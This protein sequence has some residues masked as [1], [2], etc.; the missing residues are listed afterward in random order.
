MAEPGN[1][2]GAGALAEALVTLVPLRRRHLRSV[3]RIEQQV[4]PRPWS[5]GVFMGELGQHGSRHYV[6]ARAQGRLVGYA[7]LMF[8]YDEAHVTNIAVD[9]A[10]QRHH[11]GTRLLVNLFHA[12]LRRPSR[13]ITLEVRVSNTGAQAMYRRFGFETEGLRRNYYAETGED[14]LVMWARDIAHP[15]RLAILGD[16]EQTVAATTVDETVTAAGI[17][18]GGEDEAQ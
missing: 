16:I 17:E 9:P 12:A 2:V 7:G 8:G 1:D 4:Y 11:V 14:A 3:L 13:D 15:A 18:S 6:G 5:L 10:W